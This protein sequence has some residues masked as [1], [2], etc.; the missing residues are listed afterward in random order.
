MS[1][2][3]RAKSPYHVKTRCR[4]VERLPWTECLYIC[5]RD[6]DIP[7]AVDTGFPLYFKQQQC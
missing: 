4:L 7:L 3:P 6:P 1:K 5:L 2:G